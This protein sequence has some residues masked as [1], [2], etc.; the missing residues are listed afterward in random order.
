MEIINELF[1]N[2][3]HSTT[4]GLIGVAGIFTYMTIIVVTAVYRIFKGDHLEHH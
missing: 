1:H 2:V 4:Y 3:A